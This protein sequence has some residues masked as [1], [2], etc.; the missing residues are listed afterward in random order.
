MFTTED[1]AYSL[2][3]ERAHQRFQLRSTT[4]KEG[5]EPG[6]WRGLSLWLLMSGRARGPTRRAFSMTF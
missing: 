5:G 6:D 3:Y 2:L 4:L 1:V